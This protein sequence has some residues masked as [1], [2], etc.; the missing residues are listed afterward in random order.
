MTATKNTTQ[1]APAQ[2]QAQAPAPFSLA[3]YGGFGGGGGGGVVNASPHP[4]S[5]PSPPPP[6]PVQDPAARRKAAVAWANAWAFPIGPGRG[7]TN[8]QSNGSSSSSSSSSSPAFCSWLRLAFQRLIL[9]IGIKHRLDELVHL[10]IQLEKERKARRIGPGAEMAQGTRS[11]MRIRTPQEIVEQDRRER[12]GEEQEERE[13][14]KEQKQPSSSSS[15]SSPCSSSFPLLS[16]VFSLRQDIS[17]MLQVISGISRH[18]RDHR[19]NEKKDENEM[20]KKGEYQNDDDEDDDD[21]DSSSPDPDSDSS[22]L[23]PAE[24]GSLLLHLLISPTPIP[25]LE[26]HSPDFHLPPYVFLKQG[27]I[28][29][30]LGG[31]RGGIVERGGRRRVCSCSSTSSSCSSCSPC[32]HQVNSRNLMFPHMHWKPREESQ[33]NRNR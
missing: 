14:E 19:E 26:S 32:F 18:R 1:A 8:S 20:K 21:D 33:S 6:P 10:S 12:E 2:V 15:S 23:D 27:E 9:E 11:I 24:E 31:F 4:K 30:P 25:F 5:S 17:L 29:L 16:G 22:A 7:R 3:G 13:E 28:Y